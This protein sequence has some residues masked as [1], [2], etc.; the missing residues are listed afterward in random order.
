MNTESQIHQSVSTFL[1]NAIQESG[2]DNLTNLYEIVIQEV[3]QGLLQSTMTYAKGNQ[4]IAAS[5]LTISRATLRK[6]LEIYG[7]LYHGKN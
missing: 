7:L 4:S 1:S 3:E 6:K 5:I 2:H